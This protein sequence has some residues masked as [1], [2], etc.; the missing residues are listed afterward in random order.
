MVA[1]WRE[2]G[3]MDGREQFE[4]AARLAGLRGRQ[5]VV[6]SGARS[7]AAVITWSE[8]INLTAY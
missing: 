1:E 8:R 6:Q 2:E 5:K 7:K 4:M 3:W